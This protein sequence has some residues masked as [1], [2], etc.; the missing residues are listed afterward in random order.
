MAGKT[1]THEQSVLNVLRATNITAPATTYTSLFSAAPTDTTG[2]TEVTGGGYAR[3]AAGFAA[4]SGS[5]SQISNAADILFT[6]PTV[7]VVACGLHSAVTAGTLL[8]WVGGLSVAFTSG[9]Q[10]RIAASALV[11]QED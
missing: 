2:G 9:D 11:V 5:P 8:Y 3:Q 4:P 6:M 1:Q 10:A 7:T